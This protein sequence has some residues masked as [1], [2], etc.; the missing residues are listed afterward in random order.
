MGAVATRPDDDDVS[1]EGAGVV[2]DR[3]GGATAQ[4]RRLRVDWSAPPVT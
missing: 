3:A 1:G 2:D 4:D